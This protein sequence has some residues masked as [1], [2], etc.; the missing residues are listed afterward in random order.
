MP[1][2]VFEDSD[3]PL[4]ARELAHYLYLLKAAYSRALELNLPN[5]NEV[6]RRAE[7]FGSVFRLGLPEEDIERAVD[8]LFWKDDGKLELQLSTISKSSPL[9]IGAKCVVAALTLAVILSGGE[10]EVFGMKFKLP[11]IGVGIKSLREAFQLPPIRSI[12]DGQ[13][14]G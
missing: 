13:T 9:K 8:E 6:Q 10:V 11:P 4:N 1:T 7:E 12:E 5:V 2:L 3:E 14:E